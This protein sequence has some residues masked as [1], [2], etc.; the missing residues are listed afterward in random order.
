MNVKLSKELLESLYSEHGSLK[1]VGRHLGIAGETVKNY[2]IKYGLEYKKQVRYNCNHDFFSFDN[3]ES[4]YVAGFIAADGCV[5]ARDCLY[6]GLSIKDRDF[7][8]KLKQIMGAE[9]PVLDYLARNSKRNPKWNDSW[10]SE[11]SIISKKMLN[12]LRRFNIVP[13][14][15]L[16]YQFPEWLKDHPMRNHFMR[17]Y[18]D[19]DGSFYTPKGQNQV[20]FS[21]RGTI[22][23]L[24]DFNLSMVMDNKKIRISSGCGML[25]YGGN[26]IVAKIAKFLYKDSTIRLERKHIIVSHL[27]EM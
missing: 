10:K 9:S 27:I 26:K 1:A 8:I 15:T 17:G 16:T 11:I 20:Y 24:N 23:F 21:L 3:E 18:F 25:E 4:F 22:D 14:K 6:I 19:G 5:K 7:L 12:D 2:M 13:R